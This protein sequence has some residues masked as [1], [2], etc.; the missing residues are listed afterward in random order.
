L[1][2]APTSEARR[3][4]SG[5]VG[6]VTPASGDCASGERGSVAAGSGVRLICEM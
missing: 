1:P 4:A 6:E 5:E 3:F 2:T